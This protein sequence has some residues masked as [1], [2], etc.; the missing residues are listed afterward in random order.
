M[1]SWYMNIIRTVDFF[2]PYKRTQ[3]RG[4][5]RSF[6][7]RIRCSLIIPS[8][9][10]DA[11]ILDTS[12]SCLRRF[13]ILVVGKVYSCDSR[14]NLGQINTTFHHREAPAN[15]RSSML[16]SKWTHLLVFRSKSSSCIVDVT[17]RKPG[18]NRK[19]QPRNLS[20]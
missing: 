15:R 8:M 16:S 5:G 3:R 14:Q 7:P 2:L 17:F 11:G 9:S 18:C 1:Y 12:I 10:L 19:Y 13:R 20:R 6:R 4:L